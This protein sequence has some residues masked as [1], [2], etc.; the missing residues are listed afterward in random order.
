M[1]HNNPIWVM[2]SAFPKLNL[3]ELVEKTK[4]IGAQGIDLCVFRRDGSRTDH[5]ATHLDYEN[6]DSEEAKRIIE[7][8]N[9]AELKL[10]IG[11]FENLIGGDESER[12]KNQDHLLGLIRMAQLMGGDENDVK[13]GT[14]VGYNHQIGAQEGGFQ[15]NLEEY[16]RIFTPIIKYA[17]DLGVTIIYENCPMEGWRPAGYTSTFNNLPG[18]LAAR[19][20]M[21]TLIPSKAHGEIY[22][23]SHDVWQNTDPVEVIKETDMNRLHRIHVKATRNLQNKKRTYWGSMYPVQAVDQDLAQKAD[24]PIASHE[25]DR[26]NYEAMMPGFGGSDSMDW[27]KFVDTLN[28]KGFKGPFEMENEAKNSKETGNLNTIIQG[29]KASVFFLSPMLWPLSDQGYQYD[30]NQ[31]IPLKEITSRDI[32]NTT[33]DLLNNR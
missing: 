23:P 31:Y 33:M 22:D 17:E 18:V 28:E 4:I 8:F 16:Q 29:F 13:V 12:R 1:N 5:V 30:Q 3:S 11:A 2:S 26:H 25:W 27:R 32:P 24:V 6:F 20:L 14:F 21:Y 9:K 10:S 7:I 15:K 19:K